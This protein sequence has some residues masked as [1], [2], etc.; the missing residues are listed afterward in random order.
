MIQWVLGSITF[1]NTNKKVGGRWKI[2]LLQ[3]DSEMDRRTYSKMVEVRGTDT[4]M[5]W[6][7]NHKSKS[8]SSLVSV[9]SCY[10]CKVFLRQA[11]A[12]PAHV[13]SPL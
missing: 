1:E 6:K 2:S 5:Q 4:E 13:L 9:C 11:Q 3:M 8:T 7:H 10:I 12:P